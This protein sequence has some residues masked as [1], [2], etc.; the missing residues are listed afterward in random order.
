MYR[1]YYYE[2]VIGLE[3][4]RCFILSIGEEYVM[5]VRWGGGWAGAY[6]VRGQ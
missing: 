5:K 6:A 3:Q 4:Y 2:A 1:S